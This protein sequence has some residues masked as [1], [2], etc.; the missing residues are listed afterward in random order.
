[1]ISVQKLNELA[2]LSEPNII[3]PLDLLL[4]QRNLPVGYTMRHVADAY[5]LCQLFPRAFRDRNNLTPELVLKLVQ[6]MQ[7]G[8]E[9]V[10]NHG[11]LIVDLN[12]MNFLTSR[13]FD[14]LFFID[15]DSYQ[16]PSFPA[17]VL[18]ESVR[19]RHA[20]RFTRESDWFSF[21]VITFQMFVG[22]HPFKGNYPA[23]RGCTDKAGMLDARMKA[24]I[25]VLNPGV[26]VPASC[27]PFNSIPGAFY[28]W[29][30]AVFEEG[31]RL[32]P[33]RNAIPSIVTT[34]QAQHRIESVHFEIS[35][36]HEFDSDILRIDGPITTTATSIYNGSRTS[37][38]SPRN[39]ISLISPRLGH[40]VIAYYEHGSVHFRDLT[41]AK[42]IETDLEATN[43]MQI[44]GRFYVQQR[45][46]LLE[47]AFAEMAGT[48]R[49]S[50]MVVAN[51]NQHSTQLFD[52][53]LFQNLLGAC[54]ASVILSPGRCYQI[55]LP[56]LDK[57][58]IIDARIER[59]V[60]IVLGNNSGTYDR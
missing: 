29:Y 21:A 51:V 41:A 14:D 31:K 4:D 40:M 52:G 17:K 6:Q 30:H 20:T 37:F 24:N 46:S 7:T 44:G 58:R 57:Y 23:L 60:L 12:E 35:E 16:T 48:L 39:S 26:S 8:V 50:S 43:V 54:Y 38:P 53:V 42:E 10:H 9:H 33:P 11:V 49:L 15:V 36:L 27:L 28:D 55:R 25:S 13:N 1:M 22:I 3:R 32:A 34:S 47:I 59:G 45:G 19:D 56:E 18:M 5:S 2:S